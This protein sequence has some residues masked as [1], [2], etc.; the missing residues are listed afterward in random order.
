MRGNNGTV[1]TQ[2]YYGISNIDVNDLNFAFTVDGS[3]IVF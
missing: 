3:Y 1:Y 2:G